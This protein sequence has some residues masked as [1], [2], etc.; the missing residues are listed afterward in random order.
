MG[1]DNISSVVC[2]RQTDAGKS[3]NIVVMCVC[4]YVIFCSVGRVLNN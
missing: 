2:V 4:S 1:N 3:Y